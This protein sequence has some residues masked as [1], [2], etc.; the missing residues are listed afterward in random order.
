M[1]VIHDTEVFSQLLDSIVHSYS[2]DAHSTSN[3]ELRNHVLFLQHTQTYLLLKYA[4]KH[5]DL[6]LLRQAINC[7][8][9]YFHS[10]GQSRYAYEMLYLQR[11][12]STRAATLELQ[13]AILANGLINCQ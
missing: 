8:C 6:G 3:L 5:A 13:H 12:T 4:I 1:L 9:A 10:S 2:K 7:C 11:L